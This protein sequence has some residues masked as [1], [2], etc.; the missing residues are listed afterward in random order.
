MIVGMTIPFALSF[1]IGL[2]V[3]AR[4][5]GQ[6]AVGRRHRFRTGGRR[7]GHHG[8]E[9]LPPPGR[10][11]LRAARVGSLAPRRHACPARLQWPLCHDRTG[12]RRGQ[13]LHLFCRR[14]HHRG[15]RAAVHAVRHRGAH[16]RPDGQ[17]LWL[18]HRRRT[19]RHLHDCAGAERAAAAGQDQRDRDPPD[20][21]HAPGLRSGGG[22]RTGQPRT[23]SGR[24][25]AG[26][27]AGG[28]GG[29]HARSRV[30]AQARGR[31]LL[32]SCHAAHLDLDRGRQRLRQPHAARHRLIPGSADRGL[33]ARPARTTAPMPPASSMRNSSCR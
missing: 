6:P 28:A 12:R 33:A 22:I 13:P 25:Y 26:H 23:D 7:H 21:V 32:D 11:C 18:R 14:H 3:R 19:A 2:M 20:P 30:F 31:Q 15:L 8:G 4:R 17:D 9:H 5:I 1:A 10:S 29:A 27:P 16:L 24:R